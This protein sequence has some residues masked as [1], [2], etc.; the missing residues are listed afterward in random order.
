MREEGY[1]ACTGDKRMWAGQDLKARREKITK[2]HSCKKEDYFIMELREIRRNDM[3]W[4]H[5]A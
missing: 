1:A 2:R 5:L 4:I 3:N